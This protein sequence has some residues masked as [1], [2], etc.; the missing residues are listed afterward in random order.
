EDTSLVNNDIPEHLLDTAY[1]GD[2]TATDTPTVGSMTDTGDQRRYLSKVNTPGR[3][4]APVSRRSTARSSTRK[5]TASKPNRGNLIPRAAKTFTIQVSS[6][7]SL[8]EA[9]EASQELQDMYGIESYIQR[10]FF[11]DKDEIY[12]RL[13]IGNF[14]DPAAAQSYAKEIQAMTSLPVWVDFV[15]QEM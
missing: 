14:N 10:A 2:T 9:R 1:A 4:K 11:K 5:V 8:D 12:Y 15:R 3:L 7:S 6:W 13:R